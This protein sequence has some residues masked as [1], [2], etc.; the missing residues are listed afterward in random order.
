MGPV[1]HDGT[2]TSRFIA[3]TAC[4]SAQSGDSGH[5][6]TP[7]IHGLWRTRR[8]AA[9]PGVIPCVRVQAMTASMD[10]LQADECMYFLMATSN[11]GFNMGHVVTHQVLVRTG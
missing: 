11:L 7:C 8:C 5:N 9:V 3:T 10:N 2:R 4:P 6:A 1:A